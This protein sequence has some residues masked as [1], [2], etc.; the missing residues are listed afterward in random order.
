MKILEKVYINNFRESLKKVDQD[1]YDLVYVSKA[2]QNILDNLIGNFD[3]NIAES[4]KAKLSKLIKSELLLVKTV[5][6]NDWKKALIFKIIDNLK[7]HHNNYDKGVIYNTSNL[8]FIEKYRG[9]KALKVAKEL[10]TKEIKQLPKELEEFFSTEQDYENL[11]KKDYHALLKFEECLKNIRSSCSRHLKLLKEKD[12]QGI[13]EILAINN[14]IKANDNLMDYYTASII[15]KII[16]QIK[17][18]NLINKLKTQTVSKRKTAFFVF[19]GMEKRYLPLINR[20]VDSIK[21]THNAKFSKMSNFL[22]KA[23]LK[24]FDLY[25][26]VCIGAS[27]KYYPPYYYIP[28][29]D[30]IAKFIKTNFE[31]RWIKGIYLFGVCGSFTDKKG[32]RYVPNEIS[33]LFYFFEKRVEFKD[34]RDIRKK[35]IKVD[36]CLKNVIE[37]KT[38]SKIFTCSTLFN[39]SVVHM[40]PEEYRDI[41]AKIEQDRSIPN[42]DKRERILE[43]VH[44]YKKKKFKL[45]AKHIKDK[46]IANGVEMESYVFAQNF[47]KKLG[48]YL[49]V[50]DNVLRSEDISF[51]MKTF[52]DNVSKHFDVIIEKIINE[53]EKGKNLKRKKTKIIKKRKL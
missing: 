44:E 16:I 45:F 4:E 43:A 50:S 47:P 30:D 3:P 31:D 51:D 32:T 26:V 17:L 20:Y 23:S 38:K 25:F 9:E 34:L 13:K 18:R 28:S 35:C 48:I 27:S 37:G 12:Q 1:I 41:R 24:D 14:S 53:L 46:N 52:Y 22:Y 49:E 36:N 15:R 42:K 11:I 19:G 8:R 10:L 39:E 5:L 6:R 21:K 7:N 2:K 33:N 29:A 40:L